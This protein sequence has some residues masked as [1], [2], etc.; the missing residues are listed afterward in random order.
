MKPRR[1]SAASQAVGDAVGTV[2]G[3]VALGVLVVLWL[4]GSWPVQGV[5]VVVGLVVPAAAAASILRRTPMI[6]TGADRITLFRAVLTGA[7]AT[8]VVLSLWNVVP[9]RS[10]PLFVFALPAVAF[11]AV[12]GWVARRRG[13]ASTEG[14]RLDM[15]TDAI[16]LMILSIPLAL[17]VGPWV[18]AIGAMRYL[19]FAAAT[20]R[21]ALGQRL[22]FSQFRRVVAGVQG[23]TLAVSVIPMIPVL[24]AM[25]ATGT[26]LLLLTLSFS[27]DVMTLERAHP[28]HCP[29]QSRM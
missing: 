6:S 7:C 8:V 13:N 23:V 21:P 14:G 1:S 15:E 10:W 2:V 12:D 9:F 29:E 22:N 11:D 27:R 16:L 28:R 18:L 24:V 20:V 19:F 5:A 25:I 4:G 3:S 17:S 26:A